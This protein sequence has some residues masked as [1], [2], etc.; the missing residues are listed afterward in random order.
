MCTH[1]ESISLEERV[2]SNPEEEDITKLL[3]TRNTNANGNVTVN[4]DVQGK[5]NC[6]AIL[7]SPRMSRGSLWESHNARPSGDDRSVSRSAIFGVVRRTLF[8]LHMCGL[9]HY[10]CLPDFSFAYI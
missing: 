8:V 5:V 9:F 10:T 1:T 3:Q 6:G 7:E 4:A 2:D